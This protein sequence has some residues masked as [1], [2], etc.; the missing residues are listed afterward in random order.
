MSG[1]PYP[2]PPAANSNAIGA[3]TIGVSP[4]GDIS[5]FLPFTTIISQ[6]S[7]SPTLDGIITA[8]AAACD[9]TELFDSL[10]DN[11]WSVLTAVDYGLDSWG[12]IVGVTRTLQL[13]PSTAQFF[14]FQASADPTHFTGFNQAPFYT[15]QQLT[16]TVSLSDQDFRTLI[17]AKAAANICD[18]SI[19]AINAVLLALFPNRGACY[20]T[21]PGGMQMAYTFEFALTPIELA[22]VEQSGVLPKP[23]GVAATVVQL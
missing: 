14:G 8:F 7:N 2:A 20:V 15:G 12:R 10:Y 19:P 3:F 23:V 21:D 17:L 13:P 6:Y 16:S 11:M 4:I 9:P 5:P 18:G 22:I 1:P